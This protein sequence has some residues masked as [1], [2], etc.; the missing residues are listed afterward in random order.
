MDKLNALLTRFEQF[1]LRERALI[2]AALLFA[3]YQV[4]DMT[5]NRPQDQEVSALQSQLQR[6]S[7]AIKATEQQIRQLEQRLL[8]N[9][10]VRYR[11]ETE[12]LEQ[13]LSGTE[14]RIDAFADELISPT[15]MARLLEELLTR[16]RSLSLLRLETLGSRQVIPAVLERRTEGAEAQASTRYR[17][18]RH[19]FAI[20][21]QGAYLATLKYLEALDQLPWRF[22]WDGIRYTVEQHPL[23]R[24]R[25]EL[26]T[27]SFSEGW[28][29]V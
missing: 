6:D 14:Q 22:Y 13:Q 21:F 15:D 5:L 1:S 23:G 29:G 19:D 25:L 26:H 17:V 2:A 10:A 12:R 27:L 3:L 24:V 4:W 20:E 8:A 11:Q 16:E 7:A 18:F 28:I 9:S